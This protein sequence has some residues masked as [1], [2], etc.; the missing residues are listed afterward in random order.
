MR[1]HRPFSTFVSDLGYRRQQ[2]IRKWMQ[3]T[4]STRTDL[5]I[6]HIQSTARHQLV[7]IIRTIGTNRLAVLPREYHVVV[8]GYNLDVAHHGPNTGQQTLM[9]NFHNLLLETKCR[10]PG[11]LT[12]NEHLGW[13]KRIMK[14]HLKITNLIDL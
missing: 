12:T 8:P 9:K 6:F 13:S 5:G 11:Y 4:N 1:K 14:V 2:M 10:H 3:F 7:K